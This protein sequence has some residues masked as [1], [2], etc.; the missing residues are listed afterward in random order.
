M[1]APENISWSL[2]AK[3][4]CGNAIIALID[5]GAGAG[6]IRIFSDADVLLAEPPLNIPAGNV[7]VIT[8]S[9]NLD[10]SSVAYFAVQSGAATY[11]QV[12]DSDNNMIFE[13]P[14]AEGTAAIS[15][16]IVINTLSIISGAKISVLSAVII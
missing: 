1:P 12:T 5:A 7:N 13:L 9:V 2:D 4:D 11:A 16:S 14:A 15:G 10:P 6:K 8:G 3:T